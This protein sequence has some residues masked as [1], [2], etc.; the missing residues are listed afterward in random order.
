MLQLGLT[1]PFYFVI[2]TRRGQKSKVMSEVDIK[3]SI[4]KSATIF[5]SRY[6]FHKT[7]M[8]EISRHVHKSK[9]VLYYYFKNKEELFNEALRQELGVVKAEL[10]RILTGTGDPL[11]ILK[12]YILTR[13][14][15]LSTA[16]I[17]HETLKADFFEKYEFVKGV[18]D[19]FVAFEH[20]QLTNILIRGQAEGYLDINNLEGNVNILIM[21]LQSIEFPLFLQ[22]KYA[23]YSV[24]IEELASMVLNSLMMQ[25]RT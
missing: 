18:R 15:L 16:V 11:T 8:D 13:L 21:L 4:V 24:I 2:L 20:T 12:K 5:F 9:G 22:N 6:G 3:N 14:K 7:T 25:K 17:Y 19:D 1:Q 23:E 10:S